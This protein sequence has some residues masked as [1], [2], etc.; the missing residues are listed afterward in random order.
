MVSTHKHNNAEIAHDCQDIHR[1]EEDK[2]EHLQV[3]RARESNQDKLLHLGVT[4]VAH[5]A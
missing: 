2:Q 3:L 4:S 5:S 1:E